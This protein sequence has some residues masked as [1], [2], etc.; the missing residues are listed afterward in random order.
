M[1]EFALIDLKDFDRG[2]ITSVGGVLV[3]ITVDDD[4]RQHYALNCPGLRE[5]PDESNM[6]QEIRPLPFFPDNHVPVFF[7]HPEDVFQAYILPCIIVRRGD[8]TPAF[9]RQPWWG[10]QRK[11][12]STARPVRVKV[13]ANTFI[14]G[15]DSYAEKRNP[16]PW[17]IGYEVQ[18]LARSRNDSIPLL[19]CILRAIRPPWF[20]V[21]VLDDQDCRRLYDAGDVTVSDV[22]ELSDIAD[23][24]IGWNISFTVRGELD[25][26]DETISGV[27]GAAGVITGLPE[28]TYAPPFVGGPVVVPI[29]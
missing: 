14:N 24:T 19:K 8:L 12:T 27:A 13:G 28:I 11:P 25:Q 1:A 4:V 7:M 22:S 23:R 26:D 15:F 6:P 9:D 18:A 2:V 16:W 29:P 10:F 20:S 17:D 5:Y 21:A 3:D